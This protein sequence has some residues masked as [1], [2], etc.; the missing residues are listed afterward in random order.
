MFEETVVEYLKDYYL[1]I[2]NNNTVHLEFE[3]GLC[4]DLQA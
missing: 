3:T 1:N 4:A 2:F